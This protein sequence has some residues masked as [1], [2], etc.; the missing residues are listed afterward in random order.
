M[1]GVNFGL[2]QNLTGTIKTP[3]DIGEQG[4]RTNLANAQAGQANALTDSGLY[5]AQANLAN[6]TADV[7][8]ANLSI[9][10]LN[11]LNTLSGSVMQ[12]PTQENYNAARKMAQMSGIDVKDLPEDI[13]AAMPYIKNAYVSS[14]QDLA[15]L[16]ANAKIQMAQATLGIQ[17]TNAA[18]NVAN[19][20]NT[21]INNG[22][23]APFPNAAGGGG[24]GA[25]PIVQPTGSNGYGAVP[26]GNG[27]SATPAM[28]PTGTNGGSPISQGAPAQGANQNA[29]AL[30]YPG[31]KDLGQQG[32]MFPAEKKSQEEKATNWEKLKNAV[33]SA[34][35][36]YTP[37]KN[38]IIGGRYYN[39]DRTGGEYSGVPILGWP[40]QHTPEAQLLDKYSSVGFLNTIKGLAAAGIPRLDI[41]IVN[42]ALRGN[43]SSD[44]YASVNN[45]I[46]DTQAAGNEAIG[47][48]LP[49]IMQKLDQY[50]VKDTNTA[51]QVL[52]KV[53][54]KTG[55]YDNDPNGKGAINLKA[56]EGDGWQKE[57][58]N[59]L[60][61]RTGVN[62]NSGAKV[63]YGDFV[64][65]MQKANPTLNDTQIN[66]MWNQKYM[67]SQQSPQGSQSQ[68]GQ[69]SI[70]PQAMNQTGFPR[71]DGSGNQTQQIDMPVSQASQAPIKGN[72]LDIAKQ[73]LGQ[74]ENQNTQTLGSFFQK[75]LGQ[76]I[77]P[78]VTPW[79]A[80]FV[81]SVLAS[82]G[83]KGTN[84][85]AARS[86]L[87]YGQ[88][89]DNPS[90]GDIV[91][92]SRGNDP[93]K[94]HVGFFAG[95]ENRDGQQFVKILGG[96][97][98]DGVNVKSFPA[99]MVLGYRSPPQPQEIK[100]GQD[101]VFKL[102][103]AI[104]Q[105]ESGGNYNSL[106]TPTKSGDRAY[107]KYQVMGKN[108]PTWT[109]EV[110]GRPMTPKEFLANQQA[111]DTVAYVKMQQMLQQY[112]NIDDVSS[113]W[114]SG[115][116]A[117]GNNSRDVNG[118][119]V[120]QYVNSVNKI[121]ASMT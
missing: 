19:A 57:F 16:Q 36:A 63:G 100:Q 96:N 59:V 46:F 3:M 4:A 119:S 76:N 69:N 88:S 71:Q 106:G 33:S 103:Q 82:S 120:P 87:N 81:N 86:F 68:Q 11:T 40:F 37:T 14:G 43:P 29:G 5:G 116:P 110:L 23:P 77:D 65:Q 7:N 101:Q 18:A 108:I 54:E 12:N 53:I 109:R 44:K 22:L 92:L 84:S 70:Q 117:R 15:R 17:S 21:A 107:G 38:A 42:A 34:A 85:L 102:T 99:S 32:L 45:P 1:S 55:L 62:P 83:M 24:Q 118:T 67:G 13:N 47:K 74:N 89:V 60:D 61:P 52:N 79:C 105:Q 78:R 98:N 94:G 97:Q 31:L 6:T 35:Q 115:R 50:G 9:T 66:Q 28:Q 27:Q 10:R 73:Y 90:N 56:V 49:F 114:F 95:F 58:Y 2:L 64:T 26:T 113:A 104:G 112:G 25:T 41:P 93:Q 48:M 51:T 72:P 80:A 75:S 30:Y 91:V 39:N 20:N 121:Y 111:Q 8:K